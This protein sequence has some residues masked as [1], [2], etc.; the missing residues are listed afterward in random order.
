MQ[1]RKQ[2]FA[3]AVALARF[4]FAAAYDGVSMECVTSFNWNT[5]NTDIYGSATNGDADCSGGWSTDGTKLTLSGAT[6]PRMFFKKSDGS[7][8]TFDMK[9]DR[10]S[11][12]MDL[13][14]LG[15]SFNGALYS[16]WTNATE[17]APDAAK[18]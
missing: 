12:W 14:Q 15:A 11:W 16:S 4:G 2:V 13:S 7:V 5:G 18:W 9:S 3:L 1:P 10:I 8:L 6:Q 17:N